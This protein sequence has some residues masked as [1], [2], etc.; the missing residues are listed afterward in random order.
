MAIRTLNQNNF[1][2]AFITDVHKQALEKHITVENMDYMRNGFK[3]LDSNYPR[4]YQVST[5][6]IK[7]ISSA[8]LTTKEMVDHIE[9]ITKFVWEVA[10]ITPRYVEDEWQRL[11]SQAHA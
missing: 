9:F 10:Q 1:Y 4:N 2:Y 5:M 8:E 7:P 6:A 11:L 3:E